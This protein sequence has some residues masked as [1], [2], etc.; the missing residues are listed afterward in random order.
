LTQTRGGDGDFQ[1]VRLKNAS[2]VQVAQALDEL[3][4]GAK[5]T[6][7]RIR[8]VADPNTNSLLIKA[9][10]IDLV[11]IRSLLSKAIDGEVDSRAVMRTWVIGPLKNAGARDV[12]RTL[13]DVYREFTN[14][15][16][17]AITV[18]GGPFGFFGTQAFG[19]ALVPNVDQYG[20]PVGVT[21][22]IGVDDPTNM[23]VL[24][25]SEV[26]YDE[27][28]KLVTRLD[29]AAAQSTR[30]VKVLSVKGVDP[31]LMQQAIDAIQGRRALP[32]ERSGQPPSGTGGTT[33][34]SANPITG[35]GLFPS[36]VSP[37]PPAGRYA[38]GR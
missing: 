6:K 7:E 24:H 4:N 36:G 37:T 34:E 31:A 2:A 10:P 16:N 30:T 22:S 20:N 12:A 19:S 21:L 14:N 11:T 28:N 35:Q 25:C 13:H 15:N 29:K 23:L 17:A 5:R 32:L 9:S 27:I 18:T 1:V 38:P 8:V 26:M 3:F 33:P